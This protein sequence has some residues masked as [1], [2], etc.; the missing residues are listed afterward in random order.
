[1]KTIRVTASAL[2]FH[3]Q[4]P[5]RRLLVE[6]LRLYPVVPGAHQPLSK[7]LR[8]EAAADAQA[9]LNEALAEQRAE[10]RRQIQSWLGAP[11]RFR[12]VENGFN[13]T[14][15][16]ADAEGLL[17]VLNDV[18]VGSWLLLGSPE[19]Y[20]E[21]EELERLPVELHRVWVAMELSGAFQM[22]LLQ[23]LE[24]PPPD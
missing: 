9:L 2:I 14:L 4:A 11:N 19:E 23:A 12:P 8:G 18:R 24:K 15:Q 16:R 7:S 3:L 22:A 20:L 6:M 5:E 13:F 10:L 1:V 17:Q 21:F